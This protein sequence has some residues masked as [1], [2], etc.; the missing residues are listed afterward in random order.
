MRK[1]SSGTR[2]SSHCTSSWVVFILIFREWCFDKKQ[3]IVHTHDLHNR[4]P[5]RGWWPAPVKLWILKGATGHQPRWGTY[6]LKR[7]HVK[8]EQILDLQSVIYFKL[9]QPVTQNQCTWHSTLSPW[10]CHICDTIK[11]NESEVAQNW[12]NNSFLFCYIRQLGI[13]MP[14]LAE[15][16]LEI[17]CFDPEVQTFVVWIYYPL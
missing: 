3:L 12:W 15:N 4:C 11:Q 13:S 14:S 5:C 16:P 2:W 6:S 17:G 10:S 7:L 8:R 9:F 1:I